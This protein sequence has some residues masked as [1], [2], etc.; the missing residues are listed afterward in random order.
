MAFQITLKQPDLEDTTISCDDD[1]YILDAAEEQGIDL[2]TPV[3]LVHVLHV[4]VK[5]FLVPL[6]KRTS[7]SLMMIK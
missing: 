4:L 5:L 1:Q 3:V 7:L 2:P 6:I